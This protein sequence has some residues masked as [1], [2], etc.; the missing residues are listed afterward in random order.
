MLG[1]KARAWRRRTWG[2]WGAKN[3][4]HNLG[5]GGGGGWGGKLGQSLGN[6][7]LPHQVC[8]PVCGDGIL[9]TPIE[10]CDDMNLQWGPWNQSGSRTL[11][12]AL[13]TDEPSGRVMDA[14]QTARWRP[15]SSWR[16]GVGVRE[17]MLS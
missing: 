16:L 15:S 11:E 1:Q 10:E 7:P 17:G 5:G 6:H 13:G 2:P 4:Q 14:A 3:V 8:S 12:V 9:V